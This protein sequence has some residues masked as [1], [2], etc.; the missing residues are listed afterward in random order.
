MK[1][2]VVRL[3]DINSRDEQLWRDLSCRAAEPNP[4]MEPD[5]LIPAALHLR[6]GG[7]IEIVLAE[8]DDR[9]YACIPIRALWKYHFP[10]PFV[11]TK[12]HRTLACGTP[13][14]DA[15]RGAE[16]M[17][18]ILSALSKR[19]RITRSRALD[20]P[21]VSQ[22]GPVFEACRAAAQM[23]N[24][25]FIV[26]DPFE[27]GLLRR[28]PEPGYERLF[29]PKLRRELRRLR[30]RLAEQLGTEPGLVDQTADPDAVDR[31]LRLEES[32]Y[33]AKTG[34]AMTTEAGESEFFADMCRRFAAAGHLQVSAL[35]A[36]GQTLAML[37]SLRGQ[38]GLFMF[39]MAYD[40]RYARYGPG[41]LLNVASMEYFH[42]ATDADWIDT[43]AYRDNELFL[44]LY[45]DRRRTAWIFVLLSRNPLDSAAIH[46]FIALHPVHKW[47]Y[48]KRYPKPRGAGRVSSAKGRTQPD[49]P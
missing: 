33:K 2:R 21:Q 14:V 41:I 29:S 47:I 28:Q 11:T 25:P 17:A 8:E 12:V 38:D 32:G 16:G 42:T 13:L 20:L 39:K 43:C 7:E 34:I 4:F 26:H 5:C 49:L 48:D 10:Y 40:E 15:E 30:R 44:R 23:A 24:L 35:E 1:A 22:D 37:V 27:R 36:G 31:Y 46:S 9:A 3:R 18:A 19:R 6:F 45:P